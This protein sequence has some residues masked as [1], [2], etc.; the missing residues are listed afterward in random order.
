MTSIFR[1]YLQT[2]CYPSTGIN[3]AGLNQLT[4]DNN[5]TRPN[6]PQVIPV[7]PPASATFTPTRTNAVTA[8]S[9]ADTIPDYYSASQNASMY[10]YYE[11]QSKFVTRTL[12]AAM[13]IVNS[14]YSGYGMDVR[15]GTAIV[16]LA[17][18]QTRR[19]VDIAAERIGDWPE[20][21][22]PEM[23]DAGIA[24]T[25]GSVLQ[26]IKQTVPSAKTLSKTV[27]KS[28][29]GEPLYSARF[30]A[31][32]AL[33]RAPYPTETLKVGV[34]KWQTDGATAT[35]PTLTN[36]KQEDPAA[37]NDQVTPTYGTGGGANY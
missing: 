37:D 23:M 32:L 21:P 6:S 12:R 33:S 1:C 11:M 5:P 29:N 14:P 10:T 35:T 36:S 2:P 13:P 20:F 9:V 4:T 19:I 7:V 18:S 8:A 17:P 31:V 22:D 16:K 24:T 15:A 26:P 27:T 34:N 28:I 25:Q 30:R 3:N